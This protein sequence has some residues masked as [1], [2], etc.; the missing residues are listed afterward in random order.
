MKNYPN[1]LISKGG[2][3]RELP[4]P[5]VEERVTRFVRKTRACN[6]QELREPWR[7][8]VM[9]TLVEYFEWE[10]ND[11][12]DFLGVSIKTCGKRVS[13][14]RNMYGLATLLTKNTYNGAEFVINLRDY[15]YYNI[16][17]K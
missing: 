1:L 6:P 12:A 2:G 15:I 5:E 17:R 11:A 9:Y 4:R 13:E 3:Y 10:V 8:L 14:A 16:Y 7:G